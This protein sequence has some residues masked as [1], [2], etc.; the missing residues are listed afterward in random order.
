M[1][2]KSLSGIEIKSD[3]KG[4]VEAVFSTFGVLDHDQEVTDPGAFTN[5]AECLISA[6]NHQTWQGAMPVGKGRIE[7]GAT[8]AV[9]KGQFFMNTTQ[10]RD[11]FETVKE[12][13]DLQEWSYGFDVEDEGKTDVEGKSYRLLKKLKVFEV[14]PVMRGA[15]IGTRTTGAKMRFSEQAGAVMADLGK[16]R[17]R[18]AEVM[19]MRAE[20]GKGLSDDSGNLLE[21][22]QAELKQFEDLLKQDPTPEEDTANDELRRAYMRFVASEL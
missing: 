9:L 18:A 5:G 21:Q 15:G 16:L 3:S 20:K 12:V 7:V 13:G 22:I 2:S 14:S 8:G 4:E 1:R 11:A 10:G 19:A 6:Y 17:A